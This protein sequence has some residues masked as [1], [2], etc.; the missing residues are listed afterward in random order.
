[1]EDVKPTRSELLNL[2][3]KIDLAETGHKLLKKKRDGLIMEFFDI[4]KEAKSLREDLAEKYKRAQEK[5]NVARTLESDLKIQSL[6]MA[7]EDRPEVELKEKNIVGVVVP[8]IEKGEELKSRMVERGH[9]YFNSAAITEAA[10][11]YEELV[12]MII[13]AAEIETTMRKM[14]EEIEKTKRRVN[15]LEFEV[16]PDMEDKAEYIEMRLNEQERET[17]TRLK[18]IKNR[19]EEEE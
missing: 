13:E 2:K 3:K 16:I 18:L 17:F 9:G 8:Q 14:L 15:A 19:L 11:E 12:E 7:I 10:E 5:M 1:M 4:M 6:A